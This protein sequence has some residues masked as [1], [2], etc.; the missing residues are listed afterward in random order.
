MSCSEGLDMTGVSDLAISVRSRGNK[1]QSGLSYQ[2]HYRETCVQAS[3]EHAQS[4]T[5]GLLVEARLFMLTDWFYIHLFI[6]LRRNFP[7][8]TGLV[9]ARILI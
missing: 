5:F 8:R 6:Y 2:L 9:L 4:I 3:S 1:D 7:F